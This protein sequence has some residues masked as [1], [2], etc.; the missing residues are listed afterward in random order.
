MKVN[1]RGRILISILFSIAFFPHGTRAQACRDLFTKTNLARSKSEPK[2]ETDIRRAIKDL[3]KLRIKIDLAHAAESL[4]PEMTALER[5][6]EEKQKELGAYLEAHHLMSRTE[7]ISKVKFE[8]EKLQSTRKSAELILQSDERKRQRTAV[9]DAAIDGSRVVFGTVAP[10]E[11]KLL[12]GGRWVDAKIT[13]PLHMAATLTTQLV[14]KK[15]VEAAQARFPAQYQDLNAKPSNFKSPLNPVE[16][17]SYEDIQLWFKALNALAKA[18]D[19]V[20]DEVMSSDRR[21]AAGIDEKQSGDF[22]R[23]PTEA[24]WEFVIRKRGEIK[25]GRFHFGNLDGPLHEYAWFFENSDNQT[26]PVATKEPLE[27]DGAKFFDMH[28]NVEELVLDSYA[29]RTPGGDDPVLIESRNTHVS[30]RGG[31]YHGVPIDLRIASRSGWIKT[32]RA[33][34]IGFRI[35]RVRAAETPN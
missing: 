27:I 18:H 20:I 7:L 17:I 33:P 5:A 19:D 34:D 15:I 21:A 4:S 11:F 30:K 29:F 9:L 13:K 28:G 14:W 31:S 16:M 35:V 1:L 12:A 8:I 3:A 23:L 25:E 32:G 2:L 6:S 26:Q 22:Y 10:N 24:E